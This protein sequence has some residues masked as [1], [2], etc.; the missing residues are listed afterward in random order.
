MTIN[1]EMY[2]TN[3]NLL[4]ANALGAGGAGAPVTLGD[5]AFQLNLSS[6]SDG[7]TGTLTTDGTNPFGNTGPD[8]VLLIDPYK[9]DPGDFTHGDID[10]GTGVSFTSGGPTD[11]VFTVEAVARLGKG[12][13]QG[14][15]GAGINPTDTDRLRC[16]HPAS[17][18]QFVMRTAYWPRANQLNAEAIFADNAN[19]QVSW[20]MKDI[21]ELASGNFGDDGTNYF[22]RAPIGALFFNTQTPPYFSTSPEFSTNMN[23]QSFGF[24]GSNRT[25]NLAYDYRLPYDEVYTLFRYYD[26]GSQT[27]ASDGIV[28]VFEAREGAVINDLVATGQQIVNIDQAGTGDVQGPTSITGFTYPGFMR[29]FTRHNNCNF[30]DGEMYKAIGDGAKCRVM[31]TN[32]ANYKLATKFAMQFVDQ[33]DWANGEIAINDWRTGIFQGDLTGCFLNAVGIDGIQIGSLALS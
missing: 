1:F 19:N 21:W 4:G 8:V 22:I 20:Q 32:N 18:K 33:D 10:T 3:G 16:D 9:V 29:G 24:A 14:S 12:T 27:N 26:Q 28:E 25:D 5:A 17:I 13:V 30:Y 2:R 15:T 11:K 23:G 6:L 7:A 31:I